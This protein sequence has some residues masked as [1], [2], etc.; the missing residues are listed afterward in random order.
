[1]RIE[2]DRIRKVNPEQIVVSKDLQER[3]T[4]M[5]GKR[6]KVIDYG[7]SL[8]GSDADKIPYLPS[9]TQSRAKSTRPKYP[10]DIKS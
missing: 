2:K 6:Y 3:I 4:Y 10:R 1:M 9:E 8:N 7:A 5:D